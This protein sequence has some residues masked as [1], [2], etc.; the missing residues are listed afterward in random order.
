[1]QRVVGIDV[2]R[3]LA[4]LGMFAAHLGDDQPPFPAPEGW[5]V[6]SDGRSAATF[7][8]LA[9]VSAALLTGGASPRTGSALR[10]G[11]VRILARAALLWP[12]GAVMIALG[13]P[14]VVIL[15]HYAVMFALTTLAL[16]LRRRTLLLAAAVVTVVGP[17]LRLAVREQLADGAP[18]PQGLDVLVGEHY[19]VVVWMAYLLVGVAL[20][21]TDLRAPHVP[22]RLALIGVAALVVGYGTGSIAVR[23]IDPSH[24]VP[25]A[26]LASTPHADAAPEVV[27]NIGFTLLLLA[28]ALVAARLVP[29]IMTPVAATGALALTAYCGHLVVI[30]VLGNDVVRAPSNTT[31]AAFVVVTLVIT[32]VWR[33]T[34][35]RGPV[36]R[37]LHEASTWVEDGIVPDGRRPEGGT[38]SGGR[39]DDAP[40]DLRQT[41][42]ST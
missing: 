41:R 13:T 4:V 29:R 28:G 2:V 3:G 42:A 21:R 12:L 11:A 23:L 34:I 30:A 35:G 10:H 1:M 37:L 8:L 16:R 40:E 14:V 31:L 26:L 24:T 36:E 5:L 32:T 27:G 6:V 9:G 20:G 7:A 39:Q 22:G 19:P 18:L 38:G 17:A 33:L 25:R 15:P